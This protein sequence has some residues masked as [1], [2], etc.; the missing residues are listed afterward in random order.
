MIYNIMW[1]L[2]GFTYPLSIDLEVALNY[3]QSVGYAAFVRFTT[4]H[5]EVGYPLYI[6]MMAA[7]KMGI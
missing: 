1:P 3:G 2:F 7:T 5:V 6:M 4:E